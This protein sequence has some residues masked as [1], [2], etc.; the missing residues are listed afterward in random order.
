M[1]YSIGSCLV[2]CYFLFDGFKETFKFTFWPNNSLKPSS[3][4]VVVG[5]A[6]FSLS[7]GMGTMLTYG[8]YLSRKDDIPKASLWIC[9]L[10]TSIAIAACFVVFPII[11]QNH[12]QPTGGPGLI[13]ESMPVLFNHIPVGFLFGGAFFLL[14][15][16]A[17]LTSAISITEV[18]IAYLMDHFGWKRK[19]ACIFVGVGLFVLG[20]PCINENAFS[21]AEAITDW[22]LPLASF[23]IA[24]FVGWRMPA[25]IR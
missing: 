14:V 15:A 5:Q 21:L 2:F 13:F 22:I 23:F 20:I 24:L 9:S 3:L 1:S 10:D 25:D 16:F 6:F 7:L 4:L 8:S 11:F 18:P 17:A 12:G 19:N